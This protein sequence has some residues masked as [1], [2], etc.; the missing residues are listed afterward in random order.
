MQAQE[1]EDRI[2]GRARA[3]PQIL[4]FALAF[5]C[6]S[7]A[8]YLPF[9]SLSE[10]GR[11]V[12]FVCLLVAFAL[13]GAKELSRLCRKTKRRSVRKREQALLSHHGRPLRP[14]FENRQFHEGI[15]MGALGALLGLLLSLGCT[16]AYLVHA[17]ELPQ[18]GRDCL[19][20]L[21]ED[22]QTTSYGVQ[23]VAEV[24]LPQG[25]RHVR[26]SLKDDNAE[27]LLAGDRIRASVTFMPFPDSSKEYAYEEGLWARANVTQYRQDH[28]FG[29]RGAALKV[30]KSVI[31]HLTQEGGRIGQLMAA[32]ALGYRSSFNKSTLAE[33]FRICGLAHLIAVSGAHLALV[34]AIVQGILA[35]AS[36]KRGMQAA[37]LLACLSLYAFLCAFPISVIR[38]IIMV[39][40]GI[41][42]PFVRRRRDSL[43]ALSAAIILIGLFN[44]VAL[45]S[46]SF[47]LSASSTLGIVLLAPRLNRLIRCRSRIIK[48]FIIEP[49]SITLAA[50]I[51]TL[52]ISASFFSQISLIAPLS[53]ILAAPLF[54][55][56]CLTSLLAA[57]GIALVPA[58][59]GAALA[60]GF[61][62]VEPLIMLVENL[63]AIPFAAI[64]CDLAYPVGVAGSVILTACAAYGTKNQ[65]RRYGKTILAVGGG[66]ILLAIALV[67][68]TMVSDE[69][70]MLN[71]GQGDAFIV[72][73]QG[74]SILI[75]T[76][77]EEQML[78]RAFARHGIMQLDG[79]FI[80]HADD[81]HCGSLEEVLAIAKTEAVYVANDCLACPCDSCSNL[82]KEASL[83]DGQEG[84]KGLHIGDSF[85]CGDFSFR[86]I[87]PVAYEDEGGNADSLCM[88][89]EY[90]PTGQLLLF[91]GDA[92]SEQ[93]AEIVEREHLRNIE[94]L[95]VGHHGSKA[96][97]D[98][99]LAQTLSPRIALIGV[100][101]GNRYGHPN[102]ET[103]E[104]LEKEESLVFRTDIDGDVTLEFSR[105]KLHIATQYEVVAP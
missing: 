59:T 54:T 7:D 84:L 42:A 24:R 51:P 86:I 41:V 60:L 80:T 6:A 91:T 89:A 98:D 73:S 21:A 102:A 72:R 75:D 94:V 25:I 66:M 48:D 49:L 92:E 36:L 97:L 13:L 82:R 34:A 81:D 38:A 33:D 32:L 23:A 47:I 103:L 9:F 35:K 69:V 100:G 30:R 44:P 53:N 90:R 78:R 95:K 68:R 96:A 14:V 93:L 37:L 10:R 64:P 61:Y 20:T 17:E 88:L 19:F 71:V 40:C 77:N 5:W 101:A 57:T 50:L 45:R 79:V 70:I 55:C 85:E 52:L 28:V 63:A 105:E 43:A 3:I 46:I 2:T 18:Q 56:A 39:V 16:Q 87:W 58:M 11:I 62:G 4:I 65:L 83:I 27:N 29:L 12:A 99:D 74:K 22:A 67:F 104:R 31:A 1:G 8:C 15:F 26:L 76:G